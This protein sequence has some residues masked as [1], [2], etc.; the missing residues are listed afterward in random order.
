M[1]RVLRRLHQ[2]RRLQKAYYDG[3]PADAAAVAATYLR[4]LADARAEELRRAG[5]RPP[6]VRL[7]AGSGGHVIEGWINIDVDADPTVGVA[8]DLGRSIPFRSGSVDFIHS[9]D[10]VEH[11]DAE[12]GLEFL[13]EAYRVLRPGGVM[14]IATPDLRALVTEVYLGRN[15]THLR[16][17]SEF[18]EAEGPCAAL[19]MHMRMNG[20]HRFIYDEEHL[21]R[22]LEGLGFSVKRVRYNRSEHPELRFLELRDFGLSVYLEATKPLSSPAQGGDPGGRRRMTSA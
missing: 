8:A 18:L 15:E 7:H 2:L 4:M 10:F 13:R 19:N 12:P 16:W 6:T 21:R 20:A 5:P 3:T 1:F 11:L 17:C 14:R 9:E 22:T